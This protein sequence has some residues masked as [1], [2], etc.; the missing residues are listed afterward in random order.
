MYPKELIFADSDA[1]AGVV[2]DEEEQVRKAAR[3]VFWAPLAGTEGDSEPERSK[4]SRR[5]RASGI[6]ARRPAEATSLAAALGL[7]LARL[8]GQHD[9]EV[10]FALTVV[11]GAVPAAVTWLV[12]AYRKGLRR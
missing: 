7:L 4:M 8:L 9:A 10:T 5:S 11:I 3:L 2:E 1:E 6:V 12:E